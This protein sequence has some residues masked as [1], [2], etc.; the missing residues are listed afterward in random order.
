MEK[1][2]SKMRNSQASL[3]AFSTGFSKMAQRVLLAMCCLWLCLSAEAQVRIRDLTTTPHNAVTSLTGYGLVV[4][5][6]GTGD[7]NKATF[8]PQTFA[9]MLRTFGIAVDPKNL[10]LRNVAAVIVTAE[11]RPGTRAAARLD[12][13]V[14]SLGDATS[15]QGGTLLRTVMQDPYGQ[16]VGEAQGPMSIGGFNYESAGSR[17]SQNHALVGR[18]PEGLVLLKDAPPFTVPLDSLVLNLKNP[19]IATAVKIAGAIAESFPEANARAMDVATIVAD[20]P[21]HIDTPSEKLAFAAA[22][23]HLTITPE[24]LAR[25]VINERTGTIVV[26][27]GV[28]L[29]P[30]AVAHG[31][32][33]VE[34]SERTMVSQPEPFSSGNT[35]VVPQSRIAVES[36]GTGLQ[37]IEAAPAVGDVARVLNSLGVAPRDMIAIFQALKQAGSLHAELVII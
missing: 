19:D 3:R 24:A 14:S 22:V 11:V 35:V 7:G 9:S 31:N 30:A 21:E 37:V 23:G 36:A 1:G 16:P 13:V 25:V 26:G 20:F 27:M 4:G 12:V 33:T 28:V 32:L 8:T 10:K 2:W 18:V 6:A 15:L 5:L 29:L 17:L 34:I